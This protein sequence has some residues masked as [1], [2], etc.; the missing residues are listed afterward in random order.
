[1]ISK[2]S[3]TAKFTWRLSLLSVGTP[4]TLIC[5]PSSLVTVRFNLRPIY[6]HVKRKKKRSTAHD[7]IH[8]LTCY[9]VA[10]LLRNVGW[11]EG[12]GGGEAFKAC[13]RAK[14]TRTLSS[15]LDYG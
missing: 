4:C 5:R 10:L 9:V 15:K 14:H 8:S 12:G 11:G 7:F 3:G 6:F 2:G 13:T 1:M